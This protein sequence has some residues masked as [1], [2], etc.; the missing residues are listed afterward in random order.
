M[1][2]HAAHRQ[3]LRFNDGHDALTRAKR[4]VRW[5]HVVGSSMSAESLLDHLA[6]ARD[7]L[8]E[9]TGERLALDV[10]DAAI[11]DVA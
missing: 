9:Y 1:P 5:P 7:V 3:L 6:Y 11:A 10:R 2:S 4:V 8:E